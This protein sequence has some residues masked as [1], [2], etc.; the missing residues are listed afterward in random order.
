MAVPELMIDKAVARKQSQQRQLAVELG[1]EALVEEWAL[2]ASYLPSEQRIPLT[3]QRDLQEACL[4]LM[5][6]AAELT[7][8]LPWKSWRHYGPLTPDG[9]QDILEEF[10]DVL[11]FL[12]RLMANM[13]AMFSITPEELAE[14]WKTVSERNGARFRGEIAGKEPPVSLDDEITTVL[15]VTPPAFGGISGEE[16]NSPATLEAAKKLVGG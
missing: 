12:A 5:V 4:G 14:V 3:S 8:A 2:Q 9:R 1:L 7:N 13:G 16:W 6:E 10:A 11:V 15:M